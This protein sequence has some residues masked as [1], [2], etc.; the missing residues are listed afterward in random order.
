MSLPPTS[1][2][3]NPVGPQ[4]EAFQNRYIPTSTPRED[5]EE[6]KGYMNRDTTGKV[7]RP[8]KPKE[9]ELITPDRKGKDNTY[10]SFGDNGTTASITELGQLMQFSRYLGAGSSSIFV[11]DN[12]TWEPYMM[13]YRS[14][15]LQRMA[16]NGSGFGKDIIPDD[17]NWTNQTFFLR[18]RWP[19]LVFS[20][21]SWELVSQWMVKHGVVIQQSMIENLTDQPLKFKRTFDF[22]VLI[23]DL[24]FVNP[25][26]PFNEEIDGSPYTE[27]AGPNGYG[28]VKVHRF[29][30]PN[31]PSDEHKPKTW[32]KEEEEPQAKEELESETKSK[33]EKELGGDVLSVEGAQNLEGQHA[34]ETIAAV[35][36]QHD[37]E[38]KTAVVVVDEKLSL[39]QK[40]DPLQPE[41]VGLVIGFFVDGKAKKREDFC[42]EKWHTIPPRGFLELVAGYK[43]VLLTSK[44]SEWKPL[45]LSAAD[46][47]ID[48]FLSEESSS[49]V[50]DD[51]LDY[52]TRRNLEHILSVC[53]IPV[54][55]GHVWDYDNTSVLDRLE[56]A[57]PVALTCGDMSGH[58]VCISA[59][60]WVLSDLENC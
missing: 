32:Y 4:D 16:R 8:Y 33:S 10:L 23:R 2:N 17:D 18:D 49:Y 28:F 5:D 9:N 43:L 26:Y 52:S 44:M 53:A 31:G 30:K 57:E 50:I 3:G 20:G 47:D 40:Q 12:N 55:Q 41:A 21:D 37:A 39:E 38:K 42:E 54:P 60:L 45:V 19:R 59:S 25:S 36:E 51:S 46:V 58:R 7:T 13:S 14:D 56:V 24:D 27:G 15:D 29:T 11:A 22:Q 6:F 35:G 1:S 34:A 48:R